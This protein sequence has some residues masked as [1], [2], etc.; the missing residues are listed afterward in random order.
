MGQEKTQ[1]WEPFV[2]PASASPELQ[3]KLIKLQGNFK[4]KE[5]YLGKPL[6]KIYRVH[7]PKEEFLNLRTYALH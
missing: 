1:N 7:I 4:L 3:L 6:L 5:M 2:T